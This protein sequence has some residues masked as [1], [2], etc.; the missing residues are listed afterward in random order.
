MAQISKVNYSDLSSYF[1]RIDAEFYKPISLHADEI[2]KQNAFKNLGS[3]VSEGYRVVYENTKILSPDSVNPNLDARFMQATNI[4][5]DGLWIEVNNIGFV[6]NKDWIRYPKG[7]IKKG[8]ILIEVK[9]QAEKVT[10]VQEYIPERTLVTGTLFKLS[11]KPNT[12]SHEFLFAYFSSKYGKILRDRTKVNTLIAYVSK[13]ELYR[14]PVPIPSKEI[15]EKI[16]EIVKKAFRLQKDSQSLYQQATA[17]LEQE[18]GLDNSDLDTLPNKYLSSFNAVIAGKRLDPEYFNPRA[19]TIVER[20]RSLEHTTVAKQFHVRNGF[21]WNS[22]KF[23]DDNSG[24][25]VIRIRD[26]KP[27]YIDNKKLTSIEKKYADS[28][29]FP[30]AKAGDVV[31]G[32][33]GLKYFYASLLEEDCMVNQRV[34]HIYAKENSKVSSEYVTFI[35][36]SKI[37]QAQIMRDMTIATTVGHITNMN[38]AKLIIPI[39]SDKFQKEITDLVRKSIDADKQSKQL[40]QEAKNRVEQ[41]IEAAAN[42]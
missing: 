16:T 23:L 20:I 15:N 19:R 3:L 13:P 12:V 41:L 40:L 32:M 11:L 5:V 38:V 2:I 35:I 37:G 42:Q 27:T 25:P 8:E 7:R 10:I 39:V 26:V 21:P 18:L 6:N 29:G 22:K 36:N 30:K 4:S 17:L 31:I 14:I 33:D 24:E 28:I 34:C 9:G 1:G